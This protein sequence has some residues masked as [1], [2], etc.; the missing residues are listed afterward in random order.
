M[1]IIYTSYFLILFI[2]SFIL[3]A[4]KGSLLHG[5]GQ[6]MRRGRVRTLLIF[7]H[8]QG[9]KNLGQGTNICIAK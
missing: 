3:K 2:Y 9:T 1:Q 4:E 5:L 6:A 8:H 7:S